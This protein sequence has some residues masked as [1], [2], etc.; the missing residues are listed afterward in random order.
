[1]THSPLRSS[2]QSHAALN[3]AMRIVQI[4]TYDLQGGAARAAYRLYRGLRATGHDCTMLVRDKTSTDPYVHPAILESGGARRKLERET[5]WIEK[6]Y[7]KSR[8]TPVSNTTFSSLGLGYDLSSH[9]QL[10]SADVINLHWVC[11]L[12]SPPALARLQRLGRPVIWTLHDQ[13]AFTGGCHYSAGCNH[14]EQHC[15]DCPQLLPDDLQLT[16]AA[17]QESSQHIGPNLVIVTPSR[18][19]A[20]CARRSALFRQHRIEVIPYGIDTSVFKPGRAEARAHLGL[21]PDAIHLLFG[22]DNLAE[23]RKGF[24]LLCAAVRRCLENPAFR[25]SVERQ[26]I[27]FLFFGN[28]G[29]TPTLDFPARWLGRMNSEEA[30]ARVYAACDAFLLPST[31]DNLPNTM[32]ESMCCG[33]PVI[34]FDIGGLPDAVT[35]GETGRLVAPGDVGDLAQAIQ[36]LTGDS[37]TR[38]RWSEQCARTIHPRYN[39]RS[40]AENYAALYE[41]ELSRRPATQPEPGVAQS[42]Q[43]SV[44][45]GPALGAVFP[46]L[47]Q[48]AQQERRRRRWD[49][50]RR[51]LRNK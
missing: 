10:Q 29:P 33:T 24:S 16:E 17:L 40:Q 36:E 41:S 43:A 45:F 49:P 2:I 15:W 22:A 31:E 32:I 6:Y 5:R 28:T 37:L 46:V 34:G 30:I 7:L 23:T 48:R 21:D 25:R 13:R 1:M 3:R 12:V 47:V 50:L 19:L 4:S 26:Q 42:T 44:A 20:D 11:G 18:W 39:L 35:S 27:N 14:Y 51:L 38:R 8:R 9:G